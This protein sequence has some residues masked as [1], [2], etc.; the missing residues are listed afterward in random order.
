M[1]GSASWMN[2]YFLCSLIMIRL[3]SL[4]WKLSSILKSIAI[5]VPL[6]STLLVAYTFWYVVLY[7][8]LISNANFPLIYTLAHGSHRSRLYWIF[9]FLLP[10]HWFLLL[11]C[12]AS[13]VFL[14]FLLCSYT[15]KNVTSSWW[16][17]LL[18]IMNWPSF[19]HLIGL[20]FTLLLK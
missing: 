17:D 9:K 13:G 15:F 19:P 7:F 16:M 3:R 5:N 12:L 10:N 18:F 2:F 20:N 8:H 14:I 1:F 4:I 11:I 6:S